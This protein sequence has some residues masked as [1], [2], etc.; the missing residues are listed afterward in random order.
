MA[1][2]LALE[3]SADACSVALFRDGSILQRHELLPR[4]HTLH[5]LPMVDALMAEAGV[6]L[7]ALDAI[8]FG[9]G[10]GSFTGLR[11]CASVVQGLA[12]A[13][14]IPCAPV[15]SLQALAMTALDEG[16]CIPGHD[17]LCCV[18]ARMNELYCA[19]FTPTAG[20]PVISGEERLCAPEAINWGDFEACRVGSGWRY[21]DEMGYT[22]QIDSVDILPRASAVAR[23]G[24][25]MFDLQ[26]TVS[27][28]QAL[29][30]YL[31]DDVAWR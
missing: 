31:R 13:T 25:Q 10:P 6:A 14:D 11:V 1:T 29:P 17:I 19:Q 27:V 26:Q 22:G 24:A 20:F 18:D 28:D 9:R 8:A 23:L 3:T 15:S 12:Y 4:S 30:V 21:A 2:V 16:L 5:I 7:S